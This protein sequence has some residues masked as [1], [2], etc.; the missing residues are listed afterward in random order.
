MVESL[1]LELAIKEAWKTQCQTL[2]NPAVG[3]AIL[4]KNGK[5][6][7]IDAHQEAGKP[8]AE[9]LALKNAYFHLTQDSAILSLQE[10]HQIH[11][12]LK[13]NAKD[14]FSNSTLYTTLEPCM[15]EG[16]TPSCASLIKSLGIKNLVVAAKDPN[17]KA[18]GGAEYLAN[19]NIKVTKIWEDSQFNTLAIKAQELLLPFNLLQKKGSFVLFKYACRLDGSIDGGQISSK[20]TQIFMHNLRSKLNNL[21]ISGKTILFDNPTLDSRFCSLENKNPPNITILTKNSNFPQTAPLF[22]IPNRK[23]EICHSIPNFSGFVMCEGGSN[24]LESL[25]PHID[26][27]LVF[28]SPTLSTYH[29][30]HHF[31]AHFKLLHCQMIDNDIALWLLPQK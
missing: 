7:S 4:D 9:V 2:P 16:K 25:L 14:I 23:V 27:L 11:Q 24:L 30:T 10:S 13:Q 5:L 15:H 8:H 28:V 6:L 19:S 20:E 31:Q 26:M 29:L 21:I 22:A 12:Y 17:P 18:Q 3:A 1:Y